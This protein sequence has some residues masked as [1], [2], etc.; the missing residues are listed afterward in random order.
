[1][2]YHT[3]A[4]VLSCLLD[5]HTRC[6]LD[7][8]CHNSM[9]LGV[10]ASKSRW[11]RFQHNDLDDLARRLAKSAEMDLPQTE[12]ADD[13]QIGADW[14]VTESVFSMDGDRADI[15]TVVKLARRKGA[16]T[17]VDEAHATGVLGPQ[18]M[19]LAAAKD[20]DIIM[21]TFGKGAGS[22]GAYI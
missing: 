3:N 13:V 8:Y 4:T 6:F 5:E 16:C 9:L 18:G 14:I 1:S 19:G 15:D 7:R 21:G 11:A 17:Y 22:F 2:G 10:L 20:I 12:R